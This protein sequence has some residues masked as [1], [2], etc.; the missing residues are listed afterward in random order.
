MIFFSLNLCFYFYFYRL[1]Y[2]MGQ[3]GRVNPFFKWIVLGSKGL[4]LL[5]KRVVS[6]LTLNRLAGQTG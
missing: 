3:T 5:V 1:Y 2:I 4:T 6:E